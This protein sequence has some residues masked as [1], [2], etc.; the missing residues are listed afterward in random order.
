MATY[1]EDQ[2]VEKRWY[3][4]VYLYMGGKVSGGRRNCITRVPLL[5]WHLTSVCYILLCYLLF[6]VLSRP[7]QWKACCLFL[8]WLQW[9]TLWATRTSRI[10]LGPR[11]PLKF[12]KLWNRSSLISNRHSVS[13]VWL[14]YKKHVSSGAYQIIPH[15]QVW[16]RKRWNWWKWSWAQLK[17][18]KSLITKSGD[19]PKGDCYGG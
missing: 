11:T 13:S 7:V 12:E 9:L 4:I 14:G 2:R 10:C 5:P 3:V 1:S 18:S 19:K 17:V 8:W 15:S 6:I 16:G